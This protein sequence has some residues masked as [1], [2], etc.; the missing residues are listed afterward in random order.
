MGKSK[1]EQTEKIT[2]EQKICEKHGIDMY[3]LTE[4]ATQDDE[5]GNPEEVEIQYWECL[6][7]EDEAKEKE[8]REK[9]DRLID[10][11]YLLRDTDS[12]SE[13]IERRISDPDKQK[14]Q[15]SSYSTIDLY[16]PMLSDVAQCQLEVSKAIIKFLISAQLYET[17][18]ES[19][20]G[21]IIPNLAYLWISPTAVGKDP[22]LDNGIRDFLDVMIREDGYKQYNEITG[23]EYVRSVSQILSKKNDNTIRI[24]TLSL[25]NEFSTFAKLSGTKGTNTGIETL[26]QSIDGYVQ[27]RSVVSRAEDT[28]SNVY[29]MMFGAGT[30]TFLKYISDDFWDLGLA[31]RVDILP[32]QP[33][34]LQNILP[35]RE[36]DG[37]FKKDLKVE[38]RNFRDMAKS[39]RWDPDMWEEYNR[40][41]NRTLSEVRECQMSIQDAL[42]EE[43]YEHIS[44]G[45]N[46]LKVLKHAL[47]YAVARHNY[48]ESGI[49]YVETED[50]NRAIEDL[51][52]HHAYLMELYHAWKEF[53]WKNAA[54]ANT[55]KVLRLMRTMKERFAL[56]VV[57]IPEKKK[58]V[59]PEGKMKTIQEKEIRY[60]MTPDP[61]GKSVTRSQLLMYSHLKAEG[62]G[63]L[64][65]TITTL[66]ERGLIRRHMSGDDKWIY[67]S[68]EG[69]EPKI[70]SQTFYELKG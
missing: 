24:K 22:A 12:I 56:T 6:E 26:N 40:Y 8:E 66:V 1:K 10:Q 36:A 69:K 64:D 30:P 47:I 62:Y 5:D 9:L 52:K 68:E 17:R 37:G 44:K 57:T 27:G 13:E 28:G 46:P 53:D 50:L 14:M 43:N 42:S 45:K 33:P 54:D 41:R 39:V 25:W 16:A 61:E 63:S 55:K 21:K 58:Q 67:L 3:L 15:T 7:C 38:L 51:E 4:H 48:T 2:P 49:V 18:V 29:A 20:M 32:Y 19:G 34:G 59:T 65:E 35:S 70:T 31:T 23:P 60:I 11:F